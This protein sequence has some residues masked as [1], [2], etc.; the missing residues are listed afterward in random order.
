MMT[1]HTAKGMEFDTVF[2]IGMN[3]GVFPSKRSSKP[4][5]IE[6]ERRLA[7]VAVTRARRR[8]FISDSEG[9]AHDR[10]AKTPSRFIYE[11]GL[12]NLDI[13]RALPAMPAIAPP[14]AG[15]TEKGAFAVGDRVEHPVFGVGTISAVD[16]IRQKYTVMFDSLSSSRSL[17]FG[18][19]LDP[20]K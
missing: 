10:S 7:Y 19:P 14:M 9:F 1:I 6:E 5:D 4:D 15:A 8:L 20:V 18:A 3:E 17:R 13:P 11:L 12:D 16:G 2:L